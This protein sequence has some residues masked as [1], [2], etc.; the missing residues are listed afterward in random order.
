MKVKVSCWYQLVESWPEW[1]A[2]FCQRRSSVHGG[3]W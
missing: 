2:V 1:V 3:T